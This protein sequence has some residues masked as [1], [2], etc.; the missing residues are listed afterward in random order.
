MAAIT[1]VVAEA[2]TLEAVA[3]G[4]ATQEVSG[5]KSHL[6]LADVSA[7]L[8]DD[9]APRCRARLTAWLGCS[10]WAARGRPTPE[11]EAL[12]GYLAAVAA[13]SLDF[14]RFTTLFIEKRRTPLQ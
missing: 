1:R 13:A 8:G 10:L 6:R 9:I 2:N 3:A 5:H 14:V 12:E 7:A 4:V 11:G